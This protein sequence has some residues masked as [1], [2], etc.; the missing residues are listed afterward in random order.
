[1]QRFNARQ[2][3]DRLHEIDVRLYEQMLDSISESYPDA[4]GTWDDDG[5]NM[6][7]LSLKE[8]IEDEKN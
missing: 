5:E 4:S 2:L 6:I 3:V 7:L 8:A 1:M